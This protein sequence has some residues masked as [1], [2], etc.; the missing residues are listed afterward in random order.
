MASADDA[1][2]DGPPPVPGQSS[3]GY[4][5]RPPRPPRPPASMSQNLAALA[6]TLIIVYALYFWFFVR[7]AVGPDEVLV[8]MRKDG[9]KSLPGNEYVIP[10][11]PDAKS[12][13]YAQWDKTYGD[14]N[15]V[16][17]Q[18]YLSGVYFGFSPFD[19]ERSVEKIV[20][21]PGDKV[22][23]VVKKFGQK[24]DPGQVL[25]DPKRDQRGP[26]PIVLQPGK[27]PEY[28]NQHAYD[29][30]MVNPVVITPGHRG[31]R[32]I[33]AG[34]PATRPNEY[35]VAE[36]EQGVQPIAEKEGRLLVNL[37]QERITPI[38]MQSQRFEMTGDDAIRFPSA[39]SFDIKMDG[40]VEWRIKEE[41]LPLM[42]VE[43]AEG[44][45]LIEYLD[46]KVILPYSRSFCRLVGSQFQARDFI[47]GDTKLKFQKDFETKLKEACD[48]QGIE[49]LQALVRDIIPPD[50]IKNLINER[51]IAK[52][53]IK[54]IEQ[55]ILV[56]KSSANLATQTEMAEQNTKI[57]EANKKV[58][59]ITVKAQQDMNVA[60]T[61]AEQELAVAKLH[62]QAAEK[63]AE[64][65][66]AKGQAEAA[67]VLMT[68]EAEAKPLRQQVEAFGNGDGYAQFFFYQK[69]APSIK[70]I[71]TNTDGP[72][73]DLFKDFMGSKPA[74]LPVSPVSPRPRPLDNADKTSTTQEEKP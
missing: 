53:Q 20:Q 58:V 16:M 47:S 3:D 25:A 41:M 38:S 34:R 59:T 60:V 28:S 9:S 12:A 67:V 54:T 11:A 26:L 35:L 15:G 27:Y 51:E 63:E 29:V 13:E 69:I 65:L 62:L 24:L 8:L 1:G 73:A 45:S 6:V 64:A 61:K 44:G 50:D 55:Q 14:C 68:K 71:L 52:Q 49:I 30:M 56:A 17:E 36:S 7:I 40:F 66:V 57:G 42:Y 74:A 22:G 39:D 23:L 72:F 10:K 18:V 5:P 48:K 46:E 31:V 37:Y 4:S 32:T 33:M 21:V 43:Y 70:S 19:Y 2:S